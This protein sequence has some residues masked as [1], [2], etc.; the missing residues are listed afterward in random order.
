MFLI[1]LFPPLWFAV[2][3]PRV[4]AWADGRFDRINIR[5]GYRARL[6]ARWGKRGSNAAA[7][8]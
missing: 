6:E 3:N 7:G 1:A 4:V 2:M 8:A 5:P